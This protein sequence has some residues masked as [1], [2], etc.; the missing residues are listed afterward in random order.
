LD[1]NFIPVLGLFAPVTDYV[2]PVSRSVIPAT[3]ESQSSPK[4]CVN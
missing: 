2:I 1:R 3:R 4:S